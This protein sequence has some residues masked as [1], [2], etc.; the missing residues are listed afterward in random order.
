METLTL[1][2]VGVIHTQHDTPEHTPI[3]PVCAQGS[4]GII[5][6]FPEFEEALDDIEGFSHLHLIYWLHRMGE[7]PNAVSGEH[8][9][10]VVPFLDDVPHGIFATRSPKRPNP[11][12]LSVVHLLERRGRTLVVED[13]DMFDGTPLFDIKPYVEGFDLRLGTRGG[14]TERVSGEE[15][16][17]RGERRP[18]GS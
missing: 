11:L 14:W 8:L 15:F 3:Q 1:T 5:E 17:R 9:L 10:R 7:A 4:P 6:I 16:V 13:L 2:P 18:G 12:G